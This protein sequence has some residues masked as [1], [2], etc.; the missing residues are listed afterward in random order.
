MR[1]LSGLDGDGA[2]SGLKK[3]VFW[4]AF[5]FF[6]S[7]VGYSLAQNPQYLSEAQLRPLLWAVLLA[8]PALALS[9]LRFLLSGLLIGVR[10]GWRKALEV[11][12]LGSAA[13]M[14]PLPAGTLVRV[15][16]LKNADNRYRDG[17]MA[18]GIAA[19]VWVGVACAY[20][21]MVLLWLEGPVQRSGWLF[22]SGGG[23]ALFVA[24]VMARRQPPVFLALLGV[25]SVMILVEAGRILFCLVAFGMSASFLQASVLAVSGV[26]GTLVGIVPAGLGVSEG[27]GALLAPLAGLEPEAGFMAVALNRI[28]GWCVIGAVAVSLVKGYWSRPGSGAGT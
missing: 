23:A 27:V 14:L 4:I 15:A 22:L 11:T 12:V 13:N 17:V 28:V 20:A 21:G 16:A 2:S 6:L 7:G 18:T 26:A 19:L 10:M 25:Q 5:L 9:A 3:G 1:V 24:A 8:F